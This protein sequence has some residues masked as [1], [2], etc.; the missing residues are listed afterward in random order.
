MNHKT[1][2]AWN[3]SIRLVEYVYQITSGFPKEELFGITSQIR[4]S[5][6]SI[7]S[8]IAEGVARFSNKDKL[9][10]TYISLGSLAELETQLIIAYKIGYLKT[11]EPI[12]SYI[13]NTRRLIL[14]LQKYIR[15]MVG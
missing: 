6:V 10:F 9:H 14:G 12:D 13:L 2:D 15:S 7:P 4:R 11:Y 3:H 1:L 8:N 5:A